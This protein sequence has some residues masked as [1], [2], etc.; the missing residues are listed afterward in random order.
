MRKGVFMSQETVSA[1][2]AR[3]PR[4]AKK[5]A[6]SVPVENVSIEEMDNNSTTED[7]QKVITGPKKEKPAR[8]S[9]MHTKKESAIS[10]RAADRVF[11][12]PVQEET[13]NDDKDKI[14]LWS[15]KNLSWSGVGKISKGYNIVTKEAADK[16]LSKAGIR[17]ATAQEVATYYGKD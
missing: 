13:K 17:K 9:N 2:K 1:S 10:S 12:K 14:A 11:A 3:R 8:V 7:G 6:E 16:W 4:Q 15:D 5:I